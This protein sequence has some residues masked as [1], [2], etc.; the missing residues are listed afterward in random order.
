MLKKIL[1]AL[2]INS[3]TDEAKPSEKSNVSQNKNLSRDLE[4]ESYLIEVA[5]EF[6]D[7]NQFK[8]A[9]QNIA[10]GLEFERAKKLTAYFHNNPPEPES[11]KSKTAKYGFF[12]VWMGICQDSIFEILYN[13][14][15]QAIPTLYHIGFG[16]YDWTQ[17]KAID[18]L[19]RL[20]NEGIRTNEIIKDIGDNIND[21]RYEAVFPSVESLAT[22][23]NN[24]GVPKIILRIFDE[25]S[26][27]D[28]IDGLDTLRLLAVNYPNKVKSKLAFIKSIAKGEGIENR[29][30]LL[31]GAVLTIDHEGNESYSIQGEE[32]EGNFEEV[33]RVSATAL[34]YHLDTDDKE[35]NEL[36]EFWEKNAEEEAHREMIVELKKK[37]TTPDK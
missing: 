14:K 4:L 23:P 37:K 30:P 3:G 21:F 16:V 28:P 8:I 34:Y 26:I 29:S 25:Y 5:K 22:I 36:I 32:I 9:A 11:L 13:Y 24:E 20:A 1:K 27:H 31:D 19:C 18:V 6:E 15:E 12:G 7:Q 2:G 33:H 17:Y 10:S 35:I